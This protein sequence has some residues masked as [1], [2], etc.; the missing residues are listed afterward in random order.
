MNRRLEY[1]VIGA[2]MGGVLGVIGGLLMAPSSGRET[3]RRL[4][5]QALKAAE[6]ARVVADRAEQTAEVL[7][8]RF[9]HYMGR[10]EEIAWRKVREIR[11]G[12]DRY[13]QT[14]AL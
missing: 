10:D 12:V 4:A 13:T 3:R 11:E 9:D 8:E 2:I 7:T 14:Q 6:A 1:F 5:H